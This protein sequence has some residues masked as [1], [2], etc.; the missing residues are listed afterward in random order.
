MPWVPMRIRPL[1]RYRPC[2]TASSANRNKLAKASMSDPMT[3][4]DSCAPALNAMLCLQGQ[5]VVKG[6]AIGRAV[7][8]SAAALEVE[9]YRIP[10]DDLG[11]ECAR[12]RRA[13]AMASNELQTR[14]I[15]RASSRERV[16][17]DG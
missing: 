17:Q 1:S 10:S 16:G 11:I 12:L 4:M 7:V 15:G 14:A 2:S 9:H 6:F 8:M 5:G 13:L 3:S